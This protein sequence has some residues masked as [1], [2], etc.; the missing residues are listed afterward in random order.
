[1]IEA[2]FHGV[3]ISGPSA[4]QE[5]PTAAAF[6]REI[7]TVVL[8]VGKA[9]RHPLDDFDAPLGKPLEFGR[10][11]GQQPDLG[12]SEL[13]QHFGG[14]KIKPFVGVEAELLVGV[15]RIETLVLQRIGAQFVDEADAAPL[16]CQ[17]NQNAGARLGDLGNRTLQLFA[18]IA[19]QRGEQIAGEALRM[20]AHQCRNAAIGSADN[21]GEMLGAAVGR[22]EGDHPCLFGSRQRDR[23]VA[24]YGQPARIAKPVG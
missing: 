3:R 23:R 20:D 5:M 2:G 18:A 13:A 1:M 19:A 11:V 22:A 4:L 12:K 21:Y 24:D 14:G 16:L 17:I 6:R 15:D 10:I 8:V 7:G 9:M